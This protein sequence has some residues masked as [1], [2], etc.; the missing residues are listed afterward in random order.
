[1]IKGIGTDIVRIQ[2]INEKIISRILSEKEKNIINNFKNENRKKE[3]AAGR[4]SAKEALYKALNVSFDFNAITILNRE[5]G[6]PYIDKESMI[7]LNGK[8]DKVDIKISISHE[9]E[10]AIAFVLVERR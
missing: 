9:K 10:Y 8:I 6:E 5:N 7:Y 1:M 4:F 2:R 3:F